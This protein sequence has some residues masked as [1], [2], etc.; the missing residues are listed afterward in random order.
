M[1]CTEDQQ[2][3]MCKTKGFTCYMYL[4]SKLK[5]Q[6]TVINSTVVCE[7]MAMVFLLR[8]VVLA[9]VDVVY[10]SLQVNRSRRF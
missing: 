7:I 8:P 5:I 10:S 4:V 1:G 3:K 9:L 6:Y 2:S